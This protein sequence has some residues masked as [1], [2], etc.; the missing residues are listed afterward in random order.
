MRTL[1]AHI[2]CSD[3]TSIALRTVQNVPSPISVFLDLH[4]HMLT[5]NYLMCACKQALHKKGC[6]LAVCVTSVNQLLCAHTGDTAPDT[7]SR[8]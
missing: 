6:W 2:L 8:F 3:P 4:T 7:S 5:L 1:W